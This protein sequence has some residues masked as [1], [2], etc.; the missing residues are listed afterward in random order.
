M[1][2]LRALSHVQRLRSERARTRR[3]VEAEAASRVERPAEERPVGSATERERPEPEPDLAPEL[4]LHA[5]L[6]AESRRGL[7]A[8][9]LV[10][11]AARQTYLGAEYAGPADRRSRKGR[12]LSTSV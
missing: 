1:I 4:Q 8:G 5:Q 11:G 7:R 9:P 10:L 3:R 6:N 12:R 2:E